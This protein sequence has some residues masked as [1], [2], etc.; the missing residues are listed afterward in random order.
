MIRSTVIVEGYIIDLLADI[1]TDFTYSIQDIRN[2]DKRTTDFS[3]TITI[4]GTPKNNALFAHL[5]DLNVENQF[6]PAQA[7]IGY[8]YNANKTA[9]AIVLV[10]GVEVFR[11]IIH[12]LKINVLDGQTTYETSVLGRLSDILFSLG[13]AKL[14]D[15]DF[16]DLDHTLTT[17]H[18]QDVWYNPAS[19]V[20]AYPLID[21]GISIADRDYPIEGF[22]PAIYVREYIKR[23]F[24]GAGFTYNCPFFDTPYFRNLII[25]S[26]E[27]DTFAGASGT[28][29]YL[30]AASRQRSD[31]N[32]RTGEWRLIGVWWYTPKPIDKY[33]FITIT[34]TD[35]N[36]ANHITFTR[37]IETS[38]QFSFK[39]NSSSDGYI[40]VN[41]NDA[42]L[43]SYDTGRYPDPA[44][45]NTMIIEIERRQWFMGD[46][47]TLNI[48]LPPRARTTFFSDTSVYM[49]SPTDTSTYPIDE[50]ANVI[51]SNFISKT[52]AQKDLL[53]SLIL[54]HNLYIFTDPDND[55]NLFIVPQVQFYNTFS[56]D[57]VDWTNKVDYSRDIEIVPMGELTAR[58]FLF[59]YKSDTDYYND[60]RYF[61]VYNEIYG[62]KKFTVD[63]DFEKDTTKIEAIFSPTPGVQSTITKRVIPH[64]YKVDPNTL[65]KSRD[66]FN[67]RILQYGGMLQSYLANG[68]GY[69]VWNIT[70]ATGAILLSS[71]KYPYAGMWDNPV[72]PSR[73]LEW[74]PPQE[75]F[76]TPPAT[77]YPDV[78]LFRYYWQQY[79]LEI[80]NKDSKIW[81]VYIL[82][83]PNDINRLDFKKLVKVDNIYFK[84]N[85][86][87]GYNPLMK[88]VTKVELFKTVVT[89]EVVKAGFILWSDAGY[90]LHSDGSSRIPYI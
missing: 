9:K 63:N 58:E 36:V 66:A 24:S 22:A 49:P 65:A 15:I 47:L 18:I 38:V 14:N 45:P 56:G 87:D 31:H 77:G 34:D 2:P 35:E 73:S 4:P 25:P 69:A 89:V 75:V 52:V 76:F 11:G 3:K 72:T 88:D 41:Y 90:L 48:D 54:M 57:A 13:D 39:Y 60:T 78:G 29:K 46:T 53:K 37:D 68:I 61:K 59:T 64:I 71:V 80:S 17:D 40:D 23:M 7:N 10:D 30:Q 62:Q 26:T 86:I 27:K 20:Y 70:D 83:T 50:G 81:R 42:T 55:T 51:M 84:L 12:I 21:Y 19:Y 28:V 5:F 43:Q 82:L 1:A 33:G 16:S 74:G 79:M 44:F 6:N 67:I 32:T 85:K 8:N